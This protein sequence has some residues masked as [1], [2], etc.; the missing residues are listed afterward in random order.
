MPMKRQSGVAYLTVDGTTINASGSFSVPLTTVNRTDIVCGE[1]VIGFD[2]QHIA[3]YIQATI[4]ITDQTDFE[5]IC[6]STSMTVRVEFANGKTY[7][8]SNAFVRGNPT[9]SET[10]ECSI[11]FAGEKGVWS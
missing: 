3:P 5:S 1:R 4:R 11:D 8:L 6:S 7:T 10:G 9:V 2:E